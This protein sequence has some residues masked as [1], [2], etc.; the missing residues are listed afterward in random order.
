M[1]HV[2]NN[3]VSEK[4]IYKAKKKMKENSWDWEGILIFNGGIFE[5]SNMTEMY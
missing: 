1:T 5:I 2:L 3:K 4:K